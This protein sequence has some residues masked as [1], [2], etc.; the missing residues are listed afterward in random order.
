MTAQDTPLGLRQRLIGWLTH[1][2]V[3]RQDRR[4]AWMLQLLLIVAGAMAVSI[5]VASWSGAGAVGDGERWGALAIGA[6]AWTCFV[7]LRRGRFRLSAALTIAG[8]LL[9][10]A[11]SYQA[12]GL[13][14][15]SGLQTTHV[16]PLLFAGLLLGRSA[17]WWTALAT[18]GA[19]AI[20]A[21]ADLGHATNA[22]AASEVLPNLLLSCM[23]F[24]V[25]AMILDRLILSSQRAIERSRELDAL[26]VELEREIDEKEHAYARLLQT[27]RME[28][29]GRLATGVAHDFN[30]ILSVI[31]G[32]ATSPRAQGDDADATLSRIQR[33]AQRG[34]VVTRR[35]LSFGRTQVR[36]VST[37]DLAEAI[38]EMRP[39]LLPMFPRAIRARLDT[40]PP[41]LLVTADRDELELALLNIAANACDAMPQGGRFALSI[42]ADGGH[43][44]IRVE[45]TGSGMTP[46]VR[47]RLFEP[48]FT[49]KPKDK[50]TGIGMAIVHR[51]VAD[52]GGGIDVDSAPGEGTRIRLRL[53]L[54]VP[55]CDAGQAAEAPR[56]LLVTGDAALARHATA[57][58][59][60]RGCRVIEARRG[61][62]AIAQVLQSTA[63][64]VVIAD[65]DLADTDGL[66]LLRQ[67]GNMLGK[68]RRVLI[69]DRSPAGP[70][71]DPAASDDLDDSGILRVRRPFTGEQLLATLPAIPADGGAAC[72]R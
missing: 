21:L 60:A 15:Q 30:N 29:I 45:D 17:V 41:G 50:G 39:L 42:E 1:V 36:L 61:G 33:A 66:V 55:E 9:L 18:A 19:L 14:A 44:L 10:I 3:A 69:S 62:E 59:A 64:D 8:G 53:P 2:P 67:L 11:L 4:N 31:A 37:F 12:Y 57:T 40:P 5:A 27:Q 65:H 26:C 32:L 20:G 58:L 23:S 25:L 38:E 7:L 16:M 34:A 54:A 35:L 43:A 24:L 46:D 49:T 48:F 13:R 51:F 22:A 70:S 28:A 63:I 72:G 47:A 52:S 6:Y 56:V 71:G 68:A